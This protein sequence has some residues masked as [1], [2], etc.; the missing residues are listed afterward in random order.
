MT[1]DPYRQWQKPIHTKKLHEPADSFLVLQTK[2]KYPGITHK[3]IADKLGY[4]LN[5]VEDLS[6]RYCHK[7]RLQAFH[8][9]Q[10][11][12]LA[13]MI[14]SNTYNHLKHSAEHEE[15]QNDIIN[16][17]ERLMKALQNTMLQ[18]LDDGI[19]PSK[20]ELTEY[21][22]YNNIYNDSLKTQSDVKLTDAKAVQIIT[23]KE[24]TADGD[25]TTATDFIKALHDNRKERE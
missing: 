15:Q 8:E 1:T 24:G 10:M 20:E 11:Q 22:K 4:E 25:N 21:E 9:W 16:N 7:P 5:R 23:G 17:H 14:T 12:E 3:E 19:K 2:M 6:S 13:P 18:N